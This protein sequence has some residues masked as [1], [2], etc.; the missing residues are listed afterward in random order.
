MCW[1]RL[2]LV[3][4]G[5]WM[6]CCVQG[7]FTQKEGLFFL[8]FLFFFVF[9]FGFFL[10]FFVVFIKVC[11]FFFFFFFF[12]VALEALYDKAG[13]PGWSRRNNWVS[14]SLIFFF[15]FFFFFFY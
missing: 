10:V 4:F 12:F 13:G 9:F 1:F 7:Q 8:F 3:L 2:F 11:F 14:F 15:F 5:L 6:V